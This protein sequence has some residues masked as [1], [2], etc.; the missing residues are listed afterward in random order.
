MTSG[1]IF[2]LAGTAT[3]FALLASSPLQLYERDGERPKCAA[4]RRTLDARGDEQDVFRFTR[5]RTGGATG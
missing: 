1:Q 4:E 2:I 5:V 3:R